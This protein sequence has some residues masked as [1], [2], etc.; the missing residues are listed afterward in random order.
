MNRP[1]GSALCSGLRALAAAAL[2][3]PAGLASAAC[4]VTPPALSF[5]LYDGLSATPATTSGVATVVCDE[6]PPPIVTLSLGP[7]GVSGGFFPRR[8]R[9]DGGTDTLDYNFYTDTGGTSVFGDGTGGTVTLSQRVGKNKPWSVTVYGRIVP[10]QDVSA[11]TYSDAIT[12][13]LEF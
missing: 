10:L 7:S 1:A 3:V 2:L 6:T 13:T 12:L 8:M 5:G 9:H 11:G 4:V